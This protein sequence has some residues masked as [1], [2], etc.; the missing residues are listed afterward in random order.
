MNSWGQ[1]GYTSSKGGFGIHAEVDVAT[2]DRD[3]LVAGAY[4]GRG[5][6]GQELP[7]LADP[8]QV[9]R[10]HRNLSYR[11][12]D[13]VGGCYWHSAPAGPDESGR[14]GNCFV[15]AM[16]DKRPPGQGI[17]GDM[18]HW[19]PIELW[20]SPTVVSPFG[21]AAVKAATLPPLPPA[22]GPIATRAQVAA[23]LTTF[24]VD[25]L[26]TFFHLVKA[27]ATPRRTPLILGVSTPDEGALW[28]AGLSYLL[29]PTAAREFSFSVWEA[30]ELLSRDRLPEV[31][32]ICVEEDRI[33]S[34]LADLGLEVLLAS[35][36]KP[37]DPVDPDDLAGVV[38]DLS[39]QLLSLSPEQIVEHLDQIDEIADAV[40]LDPVERTWPLVMVMARGLQQWPHLEDSITRVLQQVT[41]PGIERSRE[42]WV[43]TEE[44]IKARTLRSRLDLADIWKDAQTAAE[45]PV[46]A[47]LHQAYVELASLD[48]TWYAVPAHR[49]STP[50][51]VPRP[52]GDETSPWFRAALEATMPSPDEMGH[53]AHLV[54][55]VNFTWL[56]DFLLSREWPLSKEGLARLTQ[57]GLTSPG[58][59]LGSGADAAL[60]LRILDDV[61]SEPRQADAYLGRLGEVSAA[62]RNLVV[63]PRIERMLSSTAEMNT[64]AVADGWL[65]R[66]LLEWLVPLE[67]LAS[68]R[69]EPNLEDPLTVEALAWYLEGVDGERCVPTVVRSLTPE[70]RTPPF[71]SGRRLLDILEPHHVTGAEMT[72]LLREWGNYVPST[73]VLRSMAWA[74]ADELADLAEEVRRVSSLVSPSPKIR[75]AQDILAPLALNAVDY[76]RTSPRS[77]DQATATGLKGLYMLAELGGGS[78]DAA[79]LSEAWAPHFDL[80]VWVTDPTDWEM[81]RSNLFGAGVPVDPSAKL[82]S[83]AVRPPHQW[84]ARDFDLCR[85]LNDRLI[86]NAWY[87][88]R[89]PERVERRN[90]QGGPPLRA[91]ILDAVERHLRALPEADLADRLTTL[92]DR[93]DQGT[94]FEPDLPGVTS[95]RDVDGWLR[96]AEDWFNKMAGVSSFQKIGAMVKSLRRKR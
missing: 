74:S 49:A 32:V 43:L 9:E 48:P 90:K 82:I 44:L 34:T 84:A 95:D 59:A 93:I 25:R 31:E 80:L 62:C 26:S 96:S 68:E 23:F 35:Q 47:M 66:S 71:G 50:E 20:R 33:P 22:P 36:P 67:Q 4:A 7:L 56:M 8:D 63:R 87:A 28:L 21:I 76:L 61:L 18:W 60:P 86:L 64:R 85:K 81:K 27:C 46:R 16:V 17:D 38:A 13:G 88:S 91:P 51:A 77:I 75:F 15:H 92:L 19:R 83:D 37:A 54:A 73:T 29:S 10:F 55:A 89:W 5:S 42:L 14:T 45:G 53:D 41:P 65:N 40:P 6:F 57:H 2:G 12:V 3:V 39:L 69:A 94:H 79:R 24:E 70:M 1:L 11:R 72:L 52:E 30:P 58:E 78:A